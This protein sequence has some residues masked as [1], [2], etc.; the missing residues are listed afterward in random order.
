MNQIPIQNESGNVLF[1]KGC[2]GPDFTQISEGVLDG[3]ELGLFR[4]HQKKLEPLV[5]PA[6][7]NRVGFDKPADLGVAIGRFFS[8]HD[9]AI[10]SI[11]STG[12]IQ[13][14]PTKMNGKKLHY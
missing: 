1:V 12:K 6:E 13:R 2:T 4:F 8:S 11:A 3:G 5:K 10:D 9:K 7:T 14:V